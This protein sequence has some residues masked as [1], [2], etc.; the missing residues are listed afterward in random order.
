MIL[1]DD[2]KILLSNL[3][4]EL[5]KVTINYLLRSGLKSGSNLVKETEFV[6]TNTGLALM[7]A[8]YFQY[9][10]DGRRIGV[11]KVPI[12][13]LLDYIKRYGIR[14]RGGQT[15]TSLAFAIQTAIYKRGIQGL[16][17]FDR[18]IEATSDITEKVI[19]DEVSEV[20]AD[21][22]V[23]LMTITPYGTEVN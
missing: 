7:S 22:I 3:I 20:L 16:N 21:E 2:L 1:K 10:S 6:E 14:P 12:T 8:Y 5:N 15:L 13:A 19:A 4:P 9:R 23:R 17:Y 11:R 18:I